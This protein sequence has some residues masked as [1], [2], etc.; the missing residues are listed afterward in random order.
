MKKNIYFDTFHHIEKLH[1]MF[2]ENI[3]KKMED[4]DVYDINNVQG[5]ILYHIANGQCQ[6][7]RELINMGHYMVSNVAYH[8]RKLLDS[9]YLEPIPIPKPVSFEDMPVQISSSGKELCEHLQ[10]FFE[11]Q[12]GLFHEQGISQKNFQETAGLLHSIENFWNKNSSK[13]SQLS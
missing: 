10:N 4:M 3:S 1:R 9:G 12:E 8:V 7:V 11:E 5:L 2:L 6:T 13:E